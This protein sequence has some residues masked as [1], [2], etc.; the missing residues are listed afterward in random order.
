MR[1][2]V[3]MLTDWEDLGRTFKKGRTLRVREPEL[4]SEFY[5]TGYYLVPKMYCR[6]INAPFKRRKEA[7]D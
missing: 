1:L 4:E 5:T 6:V 2:K 7:S 3:E